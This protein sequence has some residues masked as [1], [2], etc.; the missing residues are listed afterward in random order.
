MAAGA[1]DSPDA[2]GGDGMTALESTPGAPLPD[3]GS[4]GTGSELPALPRPRGDFSVVPD[5]EPDDY[6]DVNDYDEDS[7]LGD[8]A[9]T[10]WMAKYAN[11]IAIAD[12]ITAVVA[13][14]SALLLVSPRPSQAVTIALLLLVPFAW[15]G[16]LTMARCYEP[17]FLGKG[18]DDLLRLLDVAL[19]LMGVVAVLSLLAQNPVARTFTIVAFPILIG[20]GLITRLVAHT[21][22]VRAQARGIAVHRALVVGTERATA[23]MLRRLAQRND[24]SV[25]IVGALVDR[26]REDHVE[27][28]P[29]VGH[30]HDVRR[31]LEDCE[32][33]T[34]I[35]A[36]WS[37]FSQQELRHLSWTLEDSKVDVLVTPNLTD[38]AGSRISVRPVVG[39]P[40]LH[41]ERP[42]FSGSRRVVKALFDRSVAAISLLF[43]SP[44]L[45][46][47]AIAVRLDSPGPAFF[48]Q[49][50]V[51]RNGRVF[52]MV[53]LRTM[54]VDADA[55][56][57]TLQESNEHGDG[58]LFKMKDDPRITRVG[59]VL[60]RT[61]LDELPQLINV[62][63]GEMSL[64]GPRPLI[65]EEDRHIVGHG[66]RR[67]DITP[68]LTGLWQVMGRSDIP[69]AEMVTLDYL[70]VTNWSLWGD[71]KLLARTLPAVTRGRGAY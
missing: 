40:L 26:S 3:D 16:S 46:G 20:V 19:K 49:T 47:L 11:S 8:T 30:S 12:G 17:R 45:L 61:S 25:R 5:L 33:D 52:R 66:R 65:I 32:A 14:T 2:R 27:G 9:R 43:L 37:T 58:P 68:G 48:K 6:R 54:H 56:L 29:I 31:A 67:L 13:T 64:V 71:L 35:V 36:A 10:R 1:G 42:E 22:Q 18:T 39:L 51:G 62:V 50:R 4:G 34:L 63:R 41:V 38:V 59:S 53:K 24:H 21:I 23:E 70:Y 57:E 7:A 28:V 44:F 55:M 69:F 15:L 60:R